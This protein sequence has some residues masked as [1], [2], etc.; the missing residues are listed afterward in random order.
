MHVYYLV[1][2]V[3][4]RPGYDP[5]CTLIRWGLRYLIKKADPDAQFLP[6]SDVKHDASD[7]ALMYKQATALILSGNPLYLTGTIR[8][9]WDWDIWEHISR[10]LSRGIPVADLY[11]YAMLPLPESPPQLMAAR[12]LKDPRNKRTLDVQKKFKLIITRDKCSQLIAMEVNPQAISLPCSAF[13]AA[14]YAGIKPGP[15]T[16]SAVTIRYKPGEEWIL[17]PL[18][19]L[20]RDLAAQLP[21]YIV[22]HTE[23]EYHWATKILPKDANLICLYDPFSLLDFYSR[24]KYLISTRL[25]A[26]IP[27]LSLGAKVLN[28]SIDTRST[29]LDLVDI[30]SLPYTQLK[31]PNTTYHYRS[32]E[33]S[34]LPRSEA[35]TNLFRKIML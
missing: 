16:H 12:L 28:L 4:T 1:S 11:G 24:C 18:Y 7:W 17:K 22:C 25:H 21:T 27:A 6:L 3:E 23:P 31:H 33:P 35:F 2:P 15:K 20:A 8:C 34:Q 14:R 26:T 13:W 30:S 19:Q 29:A 32:M 9:F 10:A 5:G